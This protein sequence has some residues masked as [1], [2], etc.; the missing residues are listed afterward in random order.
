MTVMAFVRNTHVQ[1]PHAAGRVLAE[2]FQ[3]AYSASARR[4]RRARD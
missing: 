4:H 2:R 3:K 1:F